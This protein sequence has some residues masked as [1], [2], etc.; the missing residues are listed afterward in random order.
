MFKNY[1]RIAIRNI[2]KHLRFSLISILGLSAGFAAAMLLMLYVKHELNFDRFHEKPEQVFRIITDNKEANS[3]EFA[4]TLNSIAPLLMEEIPEVI[5]ATRIYSLGQ[6]EVSASDQKLS[7]IRALYADSNFLKVLTFPMKE[8]LVEQPLSEP[9]TLLITEHIAIKL[10]GNESALNQIIEIDITDYD[11]SS[12]AFVKRKTNFRVTG[13]LQDL[14]VTSHLTFDMLVSFSSMPESFL[15]ILS[16]DFP[17]YLRIDESADLRESSAKV[18]E[19]GE[20]HIESIYGSLGFGRFTLRLQ[21]LLSIHLNSGFKGDYAITGEKRYIWMISIL[22]FFILSIAVLNFVNLITS[23]NATRSREVGMRKICGAMKKDI[24]LQFIGESVLVAL[25]ALTISLVF[26]ETLI[27]PFSSLVRRDLLFTYRTDW[28]LLAGFF[29][30]SLLSGLIAGLYP[31]LLAA[32]F[33]PLRIIRGMTQLGRKKPV[34]KTGMVLLQFGISFMLIT[35]LF[36][37]NRQVRFM[38]QKDLGFAKEE[39]VVLQG[40]T[41]NIRGSYTSIR[42]ELIQMEGIRGVTASQHIPGV[43]GSGMSIRLKETDPSESMAIDEYKVQDDYIETLG[44]NLL[45]GRPFSRDLQSDDEAFIL[46]ESAVKL[47]GLTDPIGKE[48]IVWQFPGKV[49]GIVKDFHFASLHRNIQPLVIS[50]YSRH[51]SLISIRLD[52]S[53]NRDILAQIRQIL[54]SYDPDYNVS[55]FYLDEFLNRSYQ[56][57]NQTNNIILSGSILAAILSFLGLYALTSY[58]IVQRRKEIAI[59]KVHGAGANTILLFLSRDTLRWVLLA[60]LLSAPITW[61]VIRK[62]LE[63]FAYRTGMDPMAYLNAFLISLILAIAAV[64]WETFRASREQPA[65]TL[66][67]E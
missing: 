6:P 53:A 1:L 33:S 29:L 56:T 36:M 31:S 7:A 14:P 57:E 32:R 28:I 37:L 18:A 38:K 47:L 22:A 26:I 52:P 55:F 60:C 50:R 59:R 23:Q 13:I 40:L 21:P 19:H 58:N 27:H 49:I 61:L 24:V 12:K 48:I 11:L 41:E 62:W 51:Y 25:I 2:G 35:S 43:Q 46:N 30:T 45:R 54:Q 63:G 17:T 4:M 16:H 8:I 64:S 39:L 20:K 42:E 67:N 9:N 10:F 3:S 44:I 66:R 34:L 5:S 65:N 15:S